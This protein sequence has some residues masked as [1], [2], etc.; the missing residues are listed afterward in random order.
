MRL[1]FSN[2][3]ERM[4]IKKEKLRQNDNS[5]AN[6]CSS[7]RPGFSF[8]R[9]FFAFFIVLVTLPIAPTVHSQTRKEIFQPGEEL[10]YKVKYGF[11]KLGTVVIQTG[12]MNADRT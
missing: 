9:A 12:Q 5:N 6:P 3:V 11:V 2:E 7:E 8:R 4:I 10:V 1:C